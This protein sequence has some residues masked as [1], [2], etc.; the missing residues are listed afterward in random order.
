MSYQTHLK[1][2]GENYKYSIT[3]IRECLYSGEG[4][5][6]NWPNVVTS[7]GMTQ[8]VNGLVTYS[9]TLTAVSANYHILSV[10]FT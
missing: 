5:I 10:L 3:K 4:P 9:S 2:N 7:E 8:T 1:I 6:Q